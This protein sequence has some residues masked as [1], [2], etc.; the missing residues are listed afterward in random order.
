M[1]LDTV[2]CRT[3]AL[4]LVRTATAADGD[5]LFD[6]VQRFAASARPSRA[7]F[8]RALGSL[9]SDPSTWLAIAECDRIAAGY[10]LGFDH[11]TLAASGRVAWIEEIM[12]R[13]VWRRR[14]VARALL[15][16]FETWARARGCRMAAA[17]TR[18]GWPLF[19]AM[20]YEEKAYLLQ[21]AL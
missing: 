3:L 20:D 5:F 16:A 1:N 10:C 17:A 12:V 13:S 18:E 14:G 8:D 4:P 11:Y 7:A 2:A 15:A 19:E 9:L 6:L 21:K